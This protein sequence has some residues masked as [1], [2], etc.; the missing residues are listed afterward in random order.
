M[1]WTLQYF[2][3]APP[4]SPTSHTILI[5]PRVLSRQMET[6]LSLFMWNKSIKLPSTYLT[7]DK[8]I[9]NISWLYLLEMPQWG[10]WKERD[11]FRLSSRLTVKML[12]VWKLFS[13]CL[14]LMKGNW[15]H[16]D[17]SITFE[18]K[19]LLFSLWWSNR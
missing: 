13:Y 6:V 15:K 7:L 19:D 12:A 1:F 8:N 2:L 14:S 17:Y 9:S 10:F 3:E 11:M 18:E 16:S 5:S 4:P